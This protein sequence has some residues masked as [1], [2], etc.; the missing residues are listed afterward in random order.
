MVGATLRTSPLWGREKEGANKG[1]PRTR[2]LSACGVKFFDAHSLG[3][4]G[5]GGG[6]QA[7]DNV[8]ISALQIRAICEICSGG[9]VTC[10]TIVSHSPVT[11]FALRFGCALRL[12]LS[13]RF[14]TAIAIGNRKEVEERGEARNS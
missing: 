3:G 10:H 12:R 4:G 8:A 14:A 1:D 11:F 7:G 2:P 5:G 6:V 9:F 13:I